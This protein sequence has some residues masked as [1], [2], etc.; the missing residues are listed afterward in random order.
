MIQFEKIK[1]AGISCCVPQEIAF[2]KDVPG[3]NQERIEKIISST[4]VSQKRVVPSGCCSS[5][6]CFAAAAD[7][8]EKTNIKKEDIGALIFVSQTPDY[9]L[10]ATACILQERLGLPTD[11]IAFDVNLG[12]S[13][14][15]YGL[16]LLG[17]IL[18]CSPKKHGLLLVGDTSTDYCSD[19]DAST[20]FL[21]GDAGSAT[22]LEADESAGSMHFSLG[23]DGSGYENLIVPAGAFRQ[24]C[25]DNTKKMIRDEAG[26]IRSAE[27]LYM[28]GMEIF[29]FAI[30]TVVPHVEEVI[31]AHPDYSAVVFHQANKYMLEFMRKSL[32]ID[33]GKFLYSLAEYGNTSSA[34]IPMTLCHNRA[35]GRELSKVILTGFGVGYSWGTAVVDMTNTKL[36]DIIEWR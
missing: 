30:A 10:P 32:K 27:N 25:D 2:N 26:N 19:K 7:L 14:Y 34:S 31:A 17:S 9:R 29:N 11:T 21:F 36:N 1:V 23:T 20:I 18:K 12:C 4:G 15:V 3:Y 13:G 6:L 33:K 5:D 24:P 22:L 8:L 35:N 16:Y 28:D